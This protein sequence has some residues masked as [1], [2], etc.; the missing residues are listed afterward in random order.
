MQENL[1]ELL[2]VAR[3]VARKGGE[4]TLE[5]FQKSI[6][7]EHKDDESPVTI[8]D[9][10]A[11]EVMRTEIADHFPDHGVLGEEL[12]QSN[13][14]HNVQWILDPIDGTISFIHGVPLYTTLVG[15]TVDQKPAVGVIY[16]PALDEM[17]D[18]AVG[19]GAYFNGESCHARRTANMKEATL[20]T[21]D[22]THI[23]KH[24]YEHQ[25]NKLHD[26]CR[27]YRSWGDAYGHMMVATGRADIML[28]PILNIWD[29]A[30]LL[31]VVSE[32]GAI[33]TGLNGESRID[34]GN[35]VSATPGLHPQ[36]ISMFNDN[37]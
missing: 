3:K 17:A 30:A 5:Y 32:S 28:D 2:E 15:I 9:R 13:E 29:A 4:Q 24:G 35:A 33:F 34:A 19:I 11:E 27:Y 23:K 12:G 7:V 6:K 21:T 1:S 8:A 22:L 25:F 31:P 36:I 14:E 18:G 37:T 10:M 16:A 20:L 26:E